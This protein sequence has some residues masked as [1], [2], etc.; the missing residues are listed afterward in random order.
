MPRMLY[1]ILVDSFIRV[2][3]TKGDDNLSKPFWE[4]EYT[5][6]NTRTFGEPSQEIIEIGNA[7]SK[8]KII[9]DM[10]CGDG[11]NAIYLAK[12]GFLVDAFDISKNGIEKLKTIALE[13]KININVWLDNILEFQYKKR[14]DFIIS[15]GVFHFLKRAEWKNAISK[16]KK[17]TKIGGVNVIVVFTDL[18]SPPDDLSPFLKGLF[19]D[20]EIKDLYS[21]WDIEMFKSYIFEDEHSNGIKHKHAANKIVAWK[22]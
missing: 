18:I 11:R 20:S 8:D 14:Y 17:N 16:M 7:L 19:K 3:V 5:N 9:L 1:E 2:S 6:K 13:N 22:R 10:G 12:K 15:H 4:E 21:D